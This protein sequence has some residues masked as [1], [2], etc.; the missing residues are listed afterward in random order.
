M[1]RQNSIAVVGGAAGWFATLTLPE[2]AGAFAGLCTGLWMLT[3]AYVL[4][5][6]QR[7]KNFDCKRRIL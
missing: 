1:T 2:L 7:C 4:L 6:R 3:Q 5:R